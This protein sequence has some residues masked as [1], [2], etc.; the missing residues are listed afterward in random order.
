[1]WLAGRQ[2]S[3]PLAEVLE[4]HQVK[5]SHFF[6]MLITLF[7]FAIYFM[8]DFMELIHYKLLLVEQKPVNQTN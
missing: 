3:T 5:I 1:M 8:L 6:P 7:L 4:D 2:R